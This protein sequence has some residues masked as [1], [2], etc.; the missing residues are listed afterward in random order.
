MRFAMIE[1]HVG[2]FPVRLV[3]RVLEASSSGFYAWR[4]RPESTRAAG[5][6]PL[7]ADVRRLQS[8]HQGRY[9]A[10][11]WHSPGCAGGTLASFAR[12]CMRR[13]LPRVAAAVA[14]ALSG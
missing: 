13:C 8:Q 12:G 11:R 10:L 2:A 14:A 4:T 1:Q 3:C 7:L 9:G 6:R 5:D